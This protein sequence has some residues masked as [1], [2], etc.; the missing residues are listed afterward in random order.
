MKKKNSG[1]R[2]GL[3]LPEDGNHL[4]IM[5]SQASLIGRHGSTRGEA[6]RCSVSIFRRCFFVLRCRF[7]WIFQ[8]GAPCGEGTLLQLW[9]GPFPVTRITFFHLHPSKR[10]TEV[11]GSAMRKLMIPPLRMSCHRSCFMI[12]YNRCMGTSLCSMHQALAV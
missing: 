1:A 12:M 6:A 8:N 2:S 5:D 7:C 3:A 11:R 9:I 4:W 10:L